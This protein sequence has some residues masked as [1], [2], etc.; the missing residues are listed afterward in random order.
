[1]EGARTATLWDTC[2]A[3]QGRTHAQPRG[4]GRELLVPKCGDGHFNLASEL[5]RLGR[6]RP[7]RWRRPSGN[8]QLAF[9]HKWPIA[10]ERPQPNDAYGSRRIP[11][12]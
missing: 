11:T 8:N 12:L 9:P 2:S 3:K 10:A 4:A 5:R 1:M 6:H 7:R